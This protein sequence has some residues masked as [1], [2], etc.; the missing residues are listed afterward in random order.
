MLKDLLFWFALQGHSWLTLQT[1]MM[2]QLHP[3]TSFLTYC[4]SSTVHTI[5]VNQLIL[6]LW[7]LFFLI[8]Y[9]TVGHNT[10]TLDFFRR[11]TENV[12]ARVTKIVML[13]SPV[14]RDDRWLEALATL[15]TCVSKFFDSSRQFVFPK[16]NQC[17]RELFNTLP[18]L[19]VF[20]TVLVWKYLEVLKYN[21]YSN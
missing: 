5:I 14:I 20:W 11:V 12:D 3:N 17:V 8:I 1:P 9:R 6:K 15:L 19:T 10:V 2:F 18:I 13:S 21:D 16:L 7:K 4:K